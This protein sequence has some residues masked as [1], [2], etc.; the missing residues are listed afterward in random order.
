[1]RSSEI[2][3]VFGYRPIALCLASGITGALIAGALIMPKPVQAT[4]VF[5]GQTGLIPLQQA[6][7]TSPTS[8]RT[9]KR[10]ATS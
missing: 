10:T 3:R 7:K 1:M 4:P 2:L 5:A 6:A 8:L 9:S